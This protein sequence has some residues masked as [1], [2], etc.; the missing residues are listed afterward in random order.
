[1]ME[2]ELERYDELMNR[3][4]IYQEEKKN[5]DLEEMERYAIDVEIGNLQ[6]EVHRIMFKLNT[7]QEDQF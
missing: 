1:M 6:D 2:R 3:I 4:K 7:C 5:P